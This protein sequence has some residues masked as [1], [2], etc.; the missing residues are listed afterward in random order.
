MTTPSLRWILRLWHGHPTYDAPVLSTPEPRMCD[1][2][3]MRRSAALLVHP[4]KRYPIARKGD[5]P[6]DLN[7]SRLKL[8]G[9]ERQSL[10]GL[11]FN[12]IG[13]VIFAD[14]GGTNRR[15]T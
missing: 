10:C 12:P 14:R 5:V 13:N 4:F 9:L 3:S 7:R 2:E 15:P 11:R 8:N 6:S 1:T